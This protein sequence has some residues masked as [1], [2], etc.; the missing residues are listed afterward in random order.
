MPASPLT[1]RGF[2]SAAL[3]AAPFSRLAAFRQIGSRVGSASRFI[4][5]VPLGNPG[6][7][8]ATPFGRLLG[9]GLDARLFTDLSQL[10]L[11]R[12]T[13]SPSPRT[14]PAAPST[15]TEEFFVR[16]AA[17]PAADGRQWQVALA[18]GGDASPVHL[19]MS[20][21]DR[22]AAPGG[23]YLVECSGNVDQANYGLMSTAD[24][25][26][27]P[28]TNVLERIG[29]PRRPYRV[30]IT[31]L[32]DHPTLSR[33]STPG[34]S[35]IF[36]PDELQRAILATRMNG[37]PL[38]PNHGAPVRLLVPGW[39]GCASI[40][41][42]NRIEFVED[43]APATSQM[44]E[45]AARTHQDASARLARDFTPAVIDTAAMPVRVE[46][47]IVDGRV[48]YRITGIVWG[49]NKPTNRLSIRFR[50]DLPWRPVDDCPLPSSMLTW[51][52]WSH[53]WRPD[54]AGRY[55]IVLRVDDPSIR[56]RRL[57]LFF[58]VRE[59]EIEEI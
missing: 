28:V 58:Y 10:G 56:T 32:D 11:T 6:G 16:T 29:A 46:K 8:P 30:L 51:N 40:K 19:T 3:L 18:S 37:S 22:M 59:I 14:S 27:V 54:S 42:V 2:L 23:R 21:L 45:F 57:D 17:P 50:S 20:D 39:Y 41:W 15:S 31:G 4:S 47:W 55:Q 35:W 12:R 5:A 48:V 9:S 24:W 49:G 36:T 38:T 26:G 13:S 33:T 7:A 1:R 53:T 25:D 52:L 44:L 43:D 34:A